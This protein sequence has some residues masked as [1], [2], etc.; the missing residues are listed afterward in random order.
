MR[1]RFFF[2]WF[3]LYTVTAG[4][5][6]TGVYAGL[7]GC[8]NYWQ[9]NWLMTPA[10]E[11]TLTG[12]YIALSMD[13][14]FGAFNAPSPGAVSFFQS[15]ASIVP[16]L[17]L[18]VF[19]SFFISA[20]YGLTHVFRRDDLI[21]GT[22]AADIVNTSEFSG[23]LRAESGL[24]FSLGSRMSLLVKGGYSYITGTNY[25]F[26]VSTGLLFKSGGRGHAA[27]TAAPQ[28]LPPPAPL[29]QESQSL[30]APAE[31]KTD[32]KKT[33]EEEKEPGEPELHF[34]KAAVIHASDF[35]IAEFNVFIESLL[36]E[37]GVTIFD[38]NVLNTV[39]KDQE[40]YPE[41]TGTVSRIAKDRF[42]IQAVVE[43]ALRYAY[44]DSYGGGVRVAHASVRILDTAG[45]R[46]IGVLTFDSGDASF[47][48]CKRYFKEHI[49]D[50]LFGTP[51]STPNQ[52]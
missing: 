22:G 24:G 46:V 20:G 32:E 39:L 30:A 38:W 36:A 1:F 21:S 4:Y 5:A 26:Y 50:I 41:D 18:P 31:K 14:T 11:V 6:Q 9:K 28:Q 25:A 48:A 7:K 44:T 34:R 10:A 19:K 37:R 15:R 8:N 49:D 13:G 12:R 51:S 42:G 16:L 3:L 45:S 35:I 52:R 43:T 47:D 40:I 23:E 2:I 33:N 29:K 27:A 17:R